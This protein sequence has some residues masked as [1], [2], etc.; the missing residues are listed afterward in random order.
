MNRNGE[1]VY[2]YSDGSLYS[3]T[4]LNGEKNGNG[5]Y[6]YANGDIYEG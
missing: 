2:K 3:G 6:Y 1:G 5:I 4:F